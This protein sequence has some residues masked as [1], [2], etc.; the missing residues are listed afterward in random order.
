MLRGNVVLNCVL[1]LVL[2]ECKTSHSFYLIVSQCSGKDTRQDHIPSEPQFVNSAILF[3]LFGYDVLHII[4]NFDNIEG[5]STQSNTSVVE[6]NILEESFI[7]G[8]PQ[9]A[10]AKL[11]LGSGDAV[12]HL[13]ICVELVVIVDRVDCFVHIV[14]FGREEVVFCP[15]RALPKYY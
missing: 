9:S 5:R 13:D 7:N 6:W 3:N 11:V 1:E 8:F 15:L 2:A 12:V 10:V 4:L 14:D